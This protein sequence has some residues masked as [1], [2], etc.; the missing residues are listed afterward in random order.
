M[1]E[2]IEKIEKVLE[3]TRKVNEWI[4]DTRRIPDDAYAWREDQRLL[5]EALGVLKS[6]AGVLN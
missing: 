4:R 5:E 1:T 3:H 2:A 6:S